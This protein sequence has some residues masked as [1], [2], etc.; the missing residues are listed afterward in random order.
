MFNGCES[1]NQDLSAWDVSNVIDM[2]YMFDSCPIKDEY[3]PK[4]K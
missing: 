2:F 4:V 1:F 3:K